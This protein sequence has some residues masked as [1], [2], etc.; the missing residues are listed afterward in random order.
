MINRI[1]KILVD[2][3]ADPVAAARAAE[4]IDRDGSV[5]DALEALEKLPTFDPLV[6][7][8]RVAESVLA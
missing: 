5:K 4:V 2:A 1:A 8:A 6:L 3:G 7:L